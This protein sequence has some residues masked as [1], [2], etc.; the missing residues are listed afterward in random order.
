ME[1]KDNNINSGT[2]EKHGNRREWVKNIII[3]FLLILL[4][5]TFFSNTIMN[6]SLPEVSVSR[7][8][9]SK[10]SKAYTLDLVVEANKN[11]I[12]TADENREIKRVA[13]RR[14]QTVKE[15]QT[16]FYL[17]GPGES[18]EAKQLEDSIDLEKTAYEKALITASPDNFAL[19]QAIEVARDK[20][21]Q[22][23]DAKNNAPSEP[24]EDPEQ[25]K[26][27]LAE[28]AVL[29]SD[30]NN[31]TEQKYELL[32][33]DTASKLS[34]EFAAFEKANSE[35]ESAKAEVRDAEDKCAGY[36]A[37][38]Q[39]A[40]AENGTKA[41]E[42]SVET[43]KLQ[44]SQKKA[45]LAA[46]S[47]ETV[48]NDLAKEIATL[49]LNLKYAEED[50]KTVTEAI[51]N[52]EKTKTLKAEKESAVAK[53]EA[54][55]LNAQTAL[56]KKVAQ[57]S[58]EINAK[59]AS[60]GGDASYDEGAASYIGSDSLS[61]STTDYDANIRAAQYELEAAINALEQK[62]K[63]DSVT[64]AQAQVDLDAQK[65]KID[66]LE[67]QLAKLNEKHSEDEIKSS[68]EGVVQSIN[69]TSGQPFTAG[70]ELMVISLSS[71]GF[72]A[73]STVSSDQAK[74]VKKGTEAKTP[75][76]DDVTVT[77]KNIVKNKNDSSK[78]DLT[79]TI[80]GDVVA[81]QQIKAELGEAASQFDKVVPK[82]AVKQDSSGKYV[83]A[84][85]SKS[86]PLGNRYLAEK[87]PVTVI[88]EDDT[89][90]A[91]S[92][93]FGDSADYIIT[94]SSKP[95]SPGDQVRLAQE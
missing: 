52:L 33:N 68:V 32:S 81:D 75:Y 22:A 85:R 72:T 29:Q 84:V 77:V 46:A 17:E 78:F 39:A 34:N 88:A 92:G 60:L 66:K 21:N 44:L 1:T 12:V 36:L 26:N 74:A 89:Q 6:Y 7:I 41:M 86:S 73:S 65:K 38:I 56:D 45:D 4:V 10:V 54:A 48:K 61:S 95:F 55:V 62:R 9:R 24:S 13:V 35:L 11:Y 91:V 49:E 76:N 94:A 25:K 87:I 20:L 31:I 90:C 8:S 23:I 58:A 15:G 70:E 37:V 51:T 71:D 59:I 83:Y 27:A 14:G 93:D 63:T 57:V 69:F 16:L 64:D 28:K 67:E 80:E 43:Q 79:F 47:E 30:L 42:R 3:V 5:L 19:A 50:L 53:K 2:A 18:S 40:G 82:N